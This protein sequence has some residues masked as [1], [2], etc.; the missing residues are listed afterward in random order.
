MLLFIIIF[1]PVCDF[2]IFLMIHYLTITCNVN[3]FMCNEKSS[4]RVRF[5]VTIK[6]AELFCII[7]DFLWRKLSRFQGY[8]WSPGNLMCWMRGIF[9]QSSTIPCQIGICLDNN[10]TGQT[11]PSGSQYTLCDSTEG[12]SVFNPISLNAGNVSTLKLKEKKVK[13]R[14]TKRRKIL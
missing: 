10:T 2:G 14:N 7:K 1:S 13:E 6:L 12:S 3:N 5:R 11:V 8:P 9:K 4:L